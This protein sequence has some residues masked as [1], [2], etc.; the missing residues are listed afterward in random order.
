M[1]TLWQVRFSYALPGL[2]PYNP[3]S[4]ISMMMHT[5]TARTV[6]MI[7]SSWR[8]IPVYP[9]FKLYKMKRK[10]RNTAICPSLEMARG[11]CPPDNSQIRGR[12]EDTD[13]TGRQESRRRA[14]LVCVV[15]QKKPWSEPG[16]E[17]R[18]GVIAFS[19][20]RSIFFLRLSLG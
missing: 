19:R 14:G 4:R 6:S 9:P 2:R 10:R 12:R 15:R 16:L 11:A 7:I 1:S 18:K 8:F 17:G 13:R 5:P 20:T 3:L